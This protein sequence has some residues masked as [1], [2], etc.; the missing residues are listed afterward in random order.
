MTLGEKIKFIRMELKMSQ[1]AFALEVGCAQ[2]LISDYE[3][4]IKRP[5]YNLLVKLDGIAKLHKIKINLL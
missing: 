3:A 4:N 5:S 2:S 1:R